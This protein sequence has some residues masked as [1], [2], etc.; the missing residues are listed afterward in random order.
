MK[1]SS[2]EEKFVVNLVLEKGKISRFVFT[3]NEIE[4]NK[5]LSDRLTNLFSELGREVKMGEFLQ[6]IKIVELIKIRIEDTKDYDT[7][8]LK[9]SIPESVYKYTAHQE[10]TEILGK[11]ND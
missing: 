10:L 4:K 1:L 7:N 8:V 9:N 11:Y 3:L 6:A 2:K 5:N